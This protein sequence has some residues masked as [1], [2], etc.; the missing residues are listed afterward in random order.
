MVGLRDA[1]TTPIL[2]V[3]PA[4]TRPLRALP[5]RRATPAVAPALT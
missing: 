4:V 1:T 5:P 2:D 3:A